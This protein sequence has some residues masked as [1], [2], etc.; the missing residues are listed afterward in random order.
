MPAAAP[1]PLT[2][3]DVTV[4][5]VTWNGLPL[6][7]RFLPSVV[8]HSE[9]AE[10][11]VVDNGSSDGTVES[12]AEAFPTVRVL[13]LDENRGFCGGN[14][15]GFA[16]AAGR[17]V[18]FLNNDVEVTPGWLSPLVAH[19]NAHPDCAAVQPKLRQ[20]DRRTHFEYAGGAGGYLDRDGFPFVRGRLFE[21]V[22]E[23]TGQ[24]DAPRPV[25]WASG[26]A[27]A[28]RRE[29]L[30]D[31]EPFDPRYFMHMEEIDLCWRLW[32]AGHSVWCAPSSVVYHVG[33]ASLAAGDPRKTYHNYRNNLLLLSRHLPRRRFLATL[34]RRSVLDATAA[35]RAAV[36][37][38]PREALAIARAYADAHRMRDAFAYGTGAL[39]RAATSHDAAP[40]PPYRRSVVADV[41][42]RGVRRFSEL[43]VDAFD[44]RLRG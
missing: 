10:V 16:A 31:A 2:T 17:V 32:S 41:F 28:V 5:I 20:H 3:A 24:Y 40:W 37:G 4:V 18:L 34:L 21:H 29:A 8:A 33:G 25:F 14:N 11:L 35:A 6:L 44:D 12:L 39:P 27:L 26:A 7:R 42:A 38:R 36:A 19:L 43:P 15:A 30:G 1:S 9:G 23:D 13:A 22:E